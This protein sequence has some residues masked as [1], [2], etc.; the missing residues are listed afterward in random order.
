MEMTLETVIR[1]QRKDNLYGKCRLFTTPNPIYVK[2][3]P[4]R[5][6]KKYFV[7]LKIYHK[8]KITAK[9][10]PDYGLYLKI[11]L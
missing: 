11:V 3:L 8:Q 10:Y 4:C 2:F 5:K 9:Y 6:G 1:E 7:W